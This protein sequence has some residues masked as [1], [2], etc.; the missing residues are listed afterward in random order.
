MDDAVRT[1]APPA[2]WTRKLARAR[3]PLGFVC[4]A[5]VLWLARPEPG[6]LMAGLPIAVVGEALRVWAA[7]HLE[8]SR[9]VTQ[10]GPYRFVRHPL[11]MGSAIMGIGLAIASTNLIVAVLTGV[12]LGT[13]IRAAIK[14]EEAFL[15]SAFGGD[16]DAYSQGRSTPG[17]PAVMRRFSFE[18]AMRNKEYRAMTGLAIASLL[19]VAKMWFLQS[20]EP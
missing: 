3:V 19:L 18:R 12:Y 15:R 20:V 1:G 7:G 10:S 2:T 14:T 8:K 4:G 16:Y 17:S 5:I 11:Y 13:T 9:E 6:L